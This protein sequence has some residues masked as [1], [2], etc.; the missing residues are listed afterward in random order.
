MKNNF[1]KESL[2][3]ILLVGMLVLILNPM[4]FWMPS[5]AHMTALTLLL[6]A[7][8]VYST[9]ILREKAVD[10]RDVLHRMVAARAA[11]FTGT[12]ILTLGVFLGALTDS[13]DKWL[14]FALVGMILAKLI[15]RYYSDKNL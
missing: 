5:M 14:V 10:E 4:D 13:V 8:I 6:V 9:F 12:T 3:A 11:F 1:F 2:V 15:A 7:F